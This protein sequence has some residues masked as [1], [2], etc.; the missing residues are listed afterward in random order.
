M[1]KIIL[2]TIFTCLFSN[3]FTQVTPFKKEYTIRQTKDWIVSSLTSVVLWENNS[4][5]KPTFPISETAFTIELKNYR[6]MNN[7][8]V[9]MAYEFSLKKAETLED[10][11]LIMDV[12]SNSGEDFI[13]FT[14]KSDDKSIYLNI[15]KDK[16]TT[17][18]K[19]R[20]IKHLN[21]AFLKLR[22]LEFL[23]F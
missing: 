1:K 12:G 23:I 2:L 7:I 13:V 3:V 8:P 16:M 4:K 20:Y 5:I 22:G 6:R 10:L 14:R 18:Q 21:N 15:N 19:H 11:D 9:S 17:E